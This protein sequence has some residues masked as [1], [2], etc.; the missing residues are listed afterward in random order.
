MN[1]QPQLPTTVHKWVWEWAQEYGEGYDD[2]PLGPLKE[3]AQHGCISG[4][5]GP[6]IYTSDIAEFYKEHLTDV[7]EIVQDWEHDTGC[8][9]HNDGHPIP[10]HHTWAAVEIAGHQL[11]S[12]LDPNW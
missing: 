2:G 1:T 4:L 5:V 6:L 8:T 9:M 12:E 10:T 3:L 7:C 11:L